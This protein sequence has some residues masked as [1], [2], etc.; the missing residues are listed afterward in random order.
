MPEPHRKRLVHFNEPGHLHFMTFSCYRR[1]PL[2]TND[3]FRKLLARALDTALESHDFQL[4]GFVVMP[5]HV[6]LLV[7]PQREEYSMAAFQQ[8]LKRPFSGR[9]KE[10]LFE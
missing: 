5:E 6:H 2:L 9:V 8:S 10:H 7:W 3:L 1:M 4:I